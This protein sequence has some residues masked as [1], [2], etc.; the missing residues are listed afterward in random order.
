MHEYY[1]NKTE[2]FITQLH[3]AARGVTVRCNTTKYPNIS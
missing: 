3:H 2:K 1:A